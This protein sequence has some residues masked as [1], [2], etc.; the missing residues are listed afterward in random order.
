[1]KHSNLFSLGIIGALAAGAQSAPAAQPPDSVTSDGG[2]NTA[3][4]SYA[5]YDLGT[6]TN[7][8]TAAGEQALEVNTTGSYNTALGY[9]SLAS[10]VSGDSNTATGVFSLVFN[11]T[12]AENSVFGTNAMF[13]NTTGSDNA[14]FGYGALYSNSTGSSNTAVGGFALYNTTASDNTAFG[15]SALNTNTTGTGNTAA[16]YFALVANS[17]GSYNS[18]FGFDALVSATTGGYTTAVGAYAL[19]VNTT[20][21]Y[22]T[23]FAA[24]ALS[25]NT[26]G[27]NNTAFGYAALRSTTTGNN[28]V[29][30]G[31]QSLYSG[32][33]GSNNIAMG[34]QAGYL[35][36]GSNNIEI[37][38]KGAIDDDS[39]IRIGTQGLQ[40]GAYIAGVS[41]AQITGAAVYVSSSGQLGVLASSERYK[42]AIA[43]MGTDTEKLQQLRPVSFHLKNDPKGAVHYPH[44]HPP[45]GRHSRLHPGRAGLFESGL[46]EQV[47]R[48][49]LGF[50]WFLIL[51]A[52]MLTGWLAS[53][54][55]QTSTSIGM[56][57]FA[58]APMSSRKR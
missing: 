35:T 9:Q 37:G 27:S 12:G 29:G 55:A 38:T 15:Y 47:A 41:S 23:A 10:N 8:N 36:D 4:G 30:F 42:T 11:T 48:F 28:N 13:T 7:D 25:A 21:G 33:T 49:M 26:T 53:R 3:M 18:A 16:G 46:A 39:V 2:G 54:T 20:G 56:Q 58:Y 19:E 45:G 34:Y 17:T 14:A 24:Y 44:L 51:G 43:P 52:F 40:T 31:F 50:N 6:T 32:K 22:D 57:Y 1:M 5:L